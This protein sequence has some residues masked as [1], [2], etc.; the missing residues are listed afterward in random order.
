MDLPPTTKAV[1]N[2][3]DDQVYEVHKLLKQIKTIPDP[4]AYDMGVKELQ[5][6]VNKKHTKPISQLVKL[7]TRFSGGFGGRVADENKDAKLYSFP[8]PSTKLKRVEGISEY[9]KN[10]TVLNQDYKTVIKRYDS[11]STFFY[12]DPPYSSTAG[13]MYKEDSINY[14]ELSNLLKSIKGKFLLSINDNSEI[15][16]LFNG[17]KIKGITVKQKNNIIDIPATRKELFIQNY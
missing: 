5:S 12:L 13:T 15:R 4:Y 14:E 11:P 3:L 17:L 1:I 16:K 2:D 6:F 7:L 8:V 10:T 9:M